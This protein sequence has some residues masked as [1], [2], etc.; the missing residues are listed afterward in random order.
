MSREF[1]Q[2]GI[3]R[4]QSC[5]ANCDVVGQSDQARFRDNGKERVY[6]PWYNEATGKNIYISTSE[7]V[8]KGMT[9]N[10]WRAANELDPWIR[11]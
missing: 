11:N 8:S 5:E 1:N 2:W 3:P 10:E 6:G 4:F 9:V 7:R